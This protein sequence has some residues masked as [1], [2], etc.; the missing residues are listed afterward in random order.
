MWAITARLLIDGL[1]LLIEL[2]FS[3]SYWFDNSLISWRA[4]SVIRFLCLV[5][6]VLIT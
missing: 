5:A 3:L 1:P 2:K 6:C 4:W